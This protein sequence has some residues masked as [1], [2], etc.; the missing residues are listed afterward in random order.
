MPRCERLTENTASIEFSD[1]EKLTAR[2]KGFFVSCWFKSLMVLGSGISI[3]PEAKI[4]LPMLV[5]PASMLRGTILPEIV[6]LA[7]SAVSSAAKVIIW[8]IAYLDFR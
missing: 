3:D 8:V 5:D 1:S 6:R 7:E 4:T 2:P